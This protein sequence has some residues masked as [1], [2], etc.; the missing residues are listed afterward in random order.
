MQ[1]VTAHVWR[2]R[3][4]H[5]GFGALAAAIPSRRLARRMGAQ[6]ARV[7]GT[8]DGGRMTL[9]GASPTTWAVLAA[10]ADEASARR[11]AE[12]RWIG[13]WSR[14]SA[15][16]GALLLAPISARGRWGGVAP[17]RPAA[18]RHGGP[19]AALTRAR[20][21]VPALR[22]FWSAV[23]PVAAQANSAP[24]LRAMLGIGETPILW[25]GTLSVWDDERSLRDFAY[26]PGAHV[27]A[28]RDQPPGGWFAEQ[29]FAQFEVLEASGS[30]GGAAVD[31]AVDADADAP[32]ADAEKDRAR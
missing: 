31:A 9:A 21:A 19:V 17:F 32:A 8:A 11:Y 3:A 29:L 10:W 25:Q 27:D 14:R 15:E 7:L 26:G 20:I 23:P 2:L 30:I 1:V 12:G 13:R 28:L 18:P 22:R 24:G 5:A 4:R 6:F 16:A